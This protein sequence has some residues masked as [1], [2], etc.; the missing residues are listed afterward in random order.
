[1]IRLTPPP[2]IELTYGQYQGWNCCYC[3]SSLAGG[4]L[5]AGTSRGNSGAHHLDIN[6]YACPPCT[7]ARRPEGADQ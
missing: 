7:A 1:M 4:G 6:V 2:V 3:N 5:P